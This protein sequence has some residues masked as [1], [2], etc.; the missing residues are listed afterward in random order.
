VQLE[1]A[2]I[3]EKGDQRWASADAPIPMSVEAFLA[4]VDA[5]RRY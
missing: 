3:S 1:K 2:V 4:E 5:D